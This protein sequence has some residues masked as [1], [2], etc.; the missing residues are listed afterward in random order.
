MHV[1]TKEK[2][3]TKNFK[4]PTA[5]WIICK[6]QKTHA[7]G[8]HYCPGGEIPAGVAMALLCINYG[9]VENGNNE[10]T[11]LERTEWVQTGATE[12]ICHS[13]FW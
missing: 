1:I 5:T 8:E 10:D 6:Y 13:K 11:D 7:E 12:T 4:N 9:A 2:L 3:C